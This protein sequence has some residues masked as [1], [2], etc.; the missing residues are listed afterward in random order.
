MISIEQQ[1]AEKL[2]AYTLP[3]NDRVNSRVKD[4]IDMILLLRLR[5]PKAEVMIQTAKKVFERR[6][7]HLLPQKL[8]TPP[9]EW[10]TPFLILATECNLSHNMQMSFKQISEFYSDLLKMTTG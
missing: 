3:R 10:Q 8:E 6:N 5:T 4:L 1:F 2:H 7:T 9:P